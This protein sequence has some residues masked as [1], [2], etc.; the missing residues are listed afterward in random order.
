MDG[1][2]ASMAFLNEALPQGTP[3]S[4]LLSNPS[5]GRFRQIHDCFRLPESNA[6]H[7]LCQMTL[8]L[9][10][11]MISSMI[12]LLKRSH[13]S[14]EEGYPFIINDKK[15][16]YGSTSGS[17]WNLGMILNKENEITVGH[18]NKRT[19]HMLFILSKWVLEEFRE[20]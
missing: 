7:S 10:V 5:Y 19:K 18:K 9:Q 4:P 11:V 15:T 20:T 1:S 2:I 13:D 16:H 12:R 8:P 14:L 6:I 3:L 17:N